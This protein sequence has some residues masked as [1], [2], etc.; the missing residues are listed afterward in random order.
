[1]I[2]ICEECGKK[3]KI[4]PEAILG[5]RARFNC[6]TC[7]NTVTVEKTSD[8][9]TA[10]DQP[11]KPALAP[12]EEALK[13][14]SEIP[15]GGA[16]SAESDPGAVK[17]NISK[18][19]MGLRSKMM[20]L[21][22]AIP[23]LIVA[24]AGIFYIWQMNSFASAMTREAGNV[25]TK[26]GQ[27]VIRDTAQAVASQ[28]RQYLLSHPELDSQDFMKDDA[29]K[30]IA[31]QKVGL[32]GYTALYAVGPMVTWVHPNPKIIGK[33]LTPLVKKPL[34]ESFGRWVQIIKGID[35]GD[36]IEK[37][38]Y[39]TWTDP[40]G[41]LREKYMFVTPVEGTK[42][43]V[44]ATIYQD[45]FT[46][47][48][49]KVKRDARKRTAAVRNT[50]IG[51]LAG[52]LLLVGIIVLIYSNVLTSRIKKLTDHA[53]QISIGELDVELDVK[54]D[55]EIGDLSEAITRMQDSIRL[56]IQRLRHRH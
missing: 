21:F 37:G 47:P 42:Y 5:K 1:M 30:K 22:L 54:S 16:P 14:K 7:G 33:P 51:I 17:N 43:G 19:G 45:E 20:L 13:T 2:V 49:K 53:E 24:G 8:M 44:A 9:Q 12:Q 11:A 41:A 48:L 18:R 3:Y 56:S 46:R 25:V 36:N 27:D 35:E 4:A 26:M 29:F 32:T 28:C 52:T 31:A 40:D 15:E 38:G 55:D 23:I 10:D 50:T 34:G 39:Y 6:K